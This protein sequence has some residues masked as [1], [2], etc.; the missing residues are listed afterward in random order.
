MDGTSSSSLI[1]Q[2]CLVIL[3]FLYFHRKLKTGM[4]LKNYVGILMG[5]ALNL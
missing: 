2:G 1:T 3:G 4:D 5:I